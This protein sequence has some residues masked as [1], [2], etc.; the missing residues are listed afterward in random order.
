LRRPRTWVLVLCVSA[1]CL[2]AMTPVQPDAIHPPQVFVSKEIR[3]RSVVYHYRV[4][5]GSPV[6]I[7]GLAIGYDPDS[8][9]VQLNFSP[10]GWSF[11]SDLHHATYGAPPGWAFEVI[12]SEEDSVGMIE[13]TSRDSTGFIGPGRSAD[14]FFVKVPSLDPPYEHGR[15]TLFP[16]LG[17]IAHFTGTLQPDSPRHRRK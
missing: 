12:P 7:A 15:W 10:S 17:D 3:D 13:W 14:Q 6:P 16:A 11:D 2:L 4:L 1:L 5:N 8:E 9:R